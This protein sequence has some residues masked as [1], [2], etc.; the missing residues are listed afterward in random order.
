MSELKVGVIGCGGHA[1]RHFAMIKNEPR[2]KLI[3]VGGVA[4]LY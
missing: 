3:L 1:Q 4:C 2:M